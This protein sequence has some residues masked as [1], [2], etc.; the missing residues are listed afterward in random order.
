MEDLKRP[1]PLDVE[2]TLNKFVKFLGGNLVSNLLSEKITTL[3]A[4]YYF[5]TPEIIAELKC[6]KKDLFANEDDAVRLIQLMEV[7]K[8][9]DYIKDGDEIKLAFGIKPL[10]K[11]CLDDLLKAAAKTIERALHKAIKQIKETRILLN[12]PKAKGL[13]LLVNDGNY[14]LSN[15]QFI[16]LT[17]SIISRKYSKEPFDAFIYITLNQVA[18]LPDSELDR[19]VWVPCY[20][21]EDTRILG[22]FIN[23]I[24]SRFFK[25]FL[26]SVTGI[27]PT[28]HIKIEDFEESM[29]VLKKLKYLPKDIAYPKKGIH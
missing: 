24:G 9:K 19:Q 25:E 12:K 29:E 1:A 27:K 3:N 22:D 21:N 2:E 4:D 13:I 11:E 23:E 10:P 16:G 18:Y 6:F 8:K 15:S 7:W 14:F 28:E 5:E 17:A 20:M 26:P